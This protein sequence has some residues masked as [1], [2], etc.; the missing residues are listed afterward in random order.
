[1]DESNIIALKDVES[2]YKTKGQEQLYLKSINLN[3]TAGE[4][5]AII[6]RSGAGKSALLR[7]IALLERPLT[8]IVAIDNKNLTFM[9]SKELC[10]ERRSIGLIAPKPNLLQSKDVFNNIALPLQIQG[11]GKDEITK[12]V[13]LA[14]ARV[15]LEN[16][17][18]QLPASLSALQQ[19]Q[20]DIARNLVNNPKILLCDDIFSGLDQKSAE[21]LI[22]I[23][24]S[25]RHD[26]NFTLLITTNDAEI[27]KTLCQNVV[28]MQQG[29]IV[30]QC[31]VYDLFTKPTSD[32]AKDFV[33]FANKHELP[34]SL[35]RKIVAQDTVDHHALV[36]ICLGNCVA[37]E[38]ILS[39]TIDAYELKM[40][41][42]QAYQDRIHDQLINI[43][44]IEIYGA[45]DT[46]QQAITFLNSNSLQSEIIGYVPNNS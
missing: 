29:A 22:N 36:R 15:G 39:N 25:L 2:T 16:K 7:C 43:M 37:P 28:V 40:N 24:R 34:N 44:L 17:A 8:G 1:M 32:V 41:I 46:V 33:R 19:I 3:V 4:I 21:T 12:Q 45:N 30:E 38:E 18:H 42:I 20:V 31:S 14:L 9:A 35:R 27:I 26:L 13:E 11:Y 6:G 23:I 5:L 10:A